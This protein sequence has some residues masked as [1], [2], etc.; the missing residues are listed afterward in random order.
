MGA[1][2]NVEGANINSTDKGSYVADSVGPMAADAPAE[3]R[4]PRN[5]NESGIIRFFFVLVSQ[6]EKIFGEFLV[7]T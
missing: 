4:N 1:R 5:S 3:S 6:S 2:A 7:F